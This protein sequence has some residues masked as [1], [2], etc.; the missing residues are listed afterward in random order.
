MVIAS[1][2][3]KNMGRILMF[4]FSEFLLLSMTM[5]QVRCHGVSEQTKT[6]SRVSRLM[7]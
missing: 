4:V 7:V 3:V 1:M 5:G 2:K 6:G